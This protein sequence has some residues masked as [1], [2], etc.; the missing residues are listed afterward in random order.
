MSAG[1]VGAAAV[2]AHDWANFD[3][4]TCRVG[5]FNP[6]NDVYLRTSL[7]LGCG[8]YE[9]LL[10]A[11]DALLRALGSDCWRYTTRTAAQDGHAHLVARVTTLLDSGVA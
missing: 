5:T 2:L 8:Y 9:S 11:P 6:R 1:P 7:I 10:D 3:V 4:T